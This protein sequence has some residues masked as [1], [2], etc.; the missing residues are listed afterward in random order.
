MAHPGGGTCSGGCSTMAHMRA[1]IASRRC[2]TPSRRRGAVAGVAGAFALYGDPES[3]SH[4]PAKAQVPGRN[5]AALWM[6]RR[7]AGAR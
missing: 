5:P 1:G 6:R 3:P 2:C 7:S 4:D